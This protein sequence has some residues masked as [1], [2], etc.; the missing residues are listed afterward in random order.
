MGTDG[1]SGG[2][3]QDGGYAAQQNPSGDYSPMQSPAG[4]YGDQ[5]APERN[6]SSEPEPTRGPSSQP[7]WIANGVNLQPSYENGG[8]NDLGWTLMLQDTRIRAVR[9][10]IEPGQ[11]VNG[12]R[13]I[14]EAFAAGYAVIATYHKSSALASDLDQELIL[15]ASWWAAYY[16]SLAQSRPLIINI[17]NEWGS[18]AIA[19]DHFARAYNQAIQTI[20]N[21]YSGLLVIDVPGSGQAVQIACNAVS[22]SAATPIADNNIALSIH[23]YPG[24]WNP[25]NNNSTLNGAMVRS[26]LDALAATGLKCVVGEFGFDGLP[27]RTQWDDLVLYAKNLGWPVFGWA[28]NGDGSGSQPPAQDMNMVQPASP[29]P[30]PHFVPYAS[31]QSATYVRT[32]YYDIVAN[33]L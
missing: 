21:V 19:P 23:V 27:G 15:A 25:A 13:W 28:W 3:N 20:R 11:E 31:G 1:G 4:G 18:N 6:Y 16:G 8:N 26:D 24:A 7:P 2:A 29:Y 32:P 5:Q 30:N 33:L 9:I 17:M 10:E 12:Q 14:S 22:P